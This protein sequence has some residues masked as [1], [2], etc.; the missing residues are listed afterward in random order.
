MHPR[1]HHQFAGSNQDPFAEST[2][3]GRLLIFTLAM[4]LLVADSA[5]ALESPKANMQLISTAFKEGEPIPARHTCDGKD[6]SPLLRWTNAPANTKSFVL[7][8]DDPDAPGGTWVHWVLYDLPPA[9]TE[10]AEDIA[11]SQ[12]LPGGARQGLNDFRRLG[13]GGPCPP[14]GKPHRYCFRLYALDTLL[15]LK[16]GAVKK[17]V[18]RAMERHILGQAQL[19][20]TYHRR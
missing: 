15:D 16:P 11:K 1:I 5:A 7:I 12:F 18:E 19:T 8:A 6:I 10:L 9:T 20:G 17:D 2:R 13:Y 14:P 3:A 4:G